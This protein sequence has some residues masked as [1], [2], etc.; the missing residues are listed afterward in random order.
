MKIKSIKQSETLLKT[1]ISNIEDLTIN[2]R[3]NPND[4]EIKIKYILKIKAKGLEY[5]SVS[6]DSRDFL[7]KLYAQNLNI[8]EKNISIT[9]TFNK[10]LNNLHILIFAE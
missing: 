9:F 8:I 10:Y 4:K 7:T 2:F 5:C 3:L 1:I 6:F